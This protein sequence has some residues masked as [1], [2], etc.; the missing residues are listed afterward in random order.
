MGSHSIA[1]HPAAVT[2]PP[3]LPSETGTRFSDPRGMQSWVVLGGAWWLHAP[4][5]TGQVNY[6]KIVYVRNMV[7]YL[8]NNRAVS[9]LGIEHT[10]VSRKS[11]VLSITPLSHISILW[12]T[13]HSCINLAFVD[14]FWKFFHCWIQQAICNKTLVVFP[15]T[16]YICF[17]TTLGNVNVKVILF[18]RLKLLQK[19]I[20][21]STKQ[22]TS[23]ANVFVCA[24]EQ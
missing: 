17:Y 21:S 15:T 9:G 3:L 14:Q 16:S 18:S 19:P 10:T 22:S 12:V 5:R 20:A 11:N 13:L 6:P 7:T 23:G 24:L 2:I 8:R 4:P 1:C